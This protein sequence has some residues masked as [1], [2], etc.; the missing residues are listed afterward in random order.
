MLA[1][2]VDICSFNKSETA[3][4]KC[5]LHVKLGRV[6]SGAKI[7]ASGFKNCPLVQD[8]WNFWKYSYRQGN[9]LVRY[10]LHWAHAL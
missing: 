1:A 4:L 2:N 7:V 5:D 8:K 6:M 3:M 10:D 9:I